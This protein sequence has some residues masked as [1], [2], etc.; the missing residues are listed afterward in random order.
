M[1][2]FQRILKV[3]R[4]VFFLINSKWTNP[5]F[6]LILPY[7][8]N[9]ITWIPFYLFLLIFMLLNHKRKAFLWILLAVATAAATDLI[10]SRLVKGH[11]FRL[12][13]CHDVLLHVRFLAQYC[14]QS[15]SFTS[16]HAA[17]HF[18]LSTF[19][20][21]TLNRFYGKWVSVIFLWAFLVSYAQVYV[22]VHYPLDV[23]GGAAVGVII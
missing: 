8:R 6:D 2:L 16:S 4:D 19:I 10:S 14:P 17:N 3:D 23:I 13:P 9:A 11:I 22:G 5:L 12:R 18:G 15:S 7:S 1:S 20:Y 21:L